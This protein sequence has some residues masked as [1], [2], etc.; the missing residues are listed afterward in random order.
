MFYSDKPIG[1]EDAY[2]KIE[3]LKNTKDFSVLNH[4]FKEVAVAFYLWCNNKDDDYHNI[5]K[6]RVDAIVSEWEK[7]K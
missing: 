4:S 3:S 7:E 2:Q 5:S 1:K 6:E